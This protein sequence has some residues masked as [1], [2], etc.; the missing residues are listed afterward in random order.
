M[1]SRLGQLNPRS[2]HL[3]IGTTKLTKLNIMGMA[4]RTESIRLREFEEPDFQRLY[5]LLKNAANRPDN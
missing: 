3:R 1:S 2:T 5:E 4:T